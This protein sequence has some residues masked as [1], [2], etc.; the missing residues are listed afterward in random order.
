MKLPTYC[1]C[2]NKIEGL[3]WCLV[4]GHTMLAEKEPTE[5]HKFIYEEEPADKEKAIHFRERLTKLV[6]YL[7]RKEDL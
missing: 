5:L 1:E 2:R 6:K 7:T 4:N 3:N